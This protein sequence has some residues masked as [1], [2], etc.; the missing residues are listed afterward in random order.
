MSEEEQQPEAPKVPAPRPPVPPPR[1]SAKTSSV[2]LKKET[3][4]ITLKSQPGEQGA[5]EAT[6][7]PASPAPAP[8]RPAAGPPTGSKTIPLTPNP[9]AGQAPAAPAAKPTVKLQ[10][11]PAARPAGQPTIQLQRTQ[12]VSSVPPKG[13][14]SSASVPTVSYD[15][16][17]EDEPAG[18]TLVAG[19]AAVLAFLLMLAAMMG[20]EKV[21]VFVQKGGSPSWGLP[22]RNNPAW[23]VRAADGTYTSNFDS[24]LA[25][26]PSRD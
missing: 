18:I 9:A 20:S 13:H 11:G 17:E 1:P 10:T 7:S 5:E 26:I 23:E 25:E 19:I 14:V 15:D 6:S 2:P 24:M 22:E 12:P 21:G 4:R 8:P 16:D 3:V